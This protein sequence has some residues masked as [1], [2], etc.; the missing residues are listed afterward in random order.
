MDSPP[1]ITI[2]SYEQDVDWNPD[3]VHQLT[4]LKNI[5]T[6]S[7]ISDNL[8]LNVEIGQRV[9]KARFELITS[10]SRTATLT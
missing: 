9:G 6:W 8:F 2:Y 5:V 3:V 7:S 1:V 10:R 4:C